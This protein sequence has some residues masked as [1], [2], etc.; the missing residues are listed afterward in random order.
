MLLHR[1]RPGPSRTSLRGAHPK[2]AYRLSRTS[3]SSCSEAVRTAKGRRLT[4]RRATAGKAALVL[5][6][7][8]CRRCADG[9]GALPRA[10]TC[11]DTPE[12]ASG[13]SAT[14]TLP[15]RSGVPEV[16][17]SRASQ[18]C[19]RTQE[20]C[21]SA[22]RSGWTGGLL[23]HVSTGSNPVRPTSENSPLAKNVLVGTM[24]IRCVT[25]R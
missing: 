7:S 22:G 15:S 20:W 5:S 10:Y 17:P 3:P 12:T 18:T 25:R 14:F 13:S 9:F 11:S 6:T 19:R 2:G 24:A 4:M 1:T 23:T 16:G 8:F 21:V